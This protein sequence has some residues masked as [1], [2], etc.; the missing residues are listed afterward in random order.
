MSS[1][2]QGNGGTGPTPTE[3]VV[4]DFEGG[5]YVRFDAPKAKLR[6]S[7]P[8]LRGTF[9]PVYS[10]LNYPLAPTDGQLHLKSFPGD[11]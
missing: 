9:D 7:W 8:G 2:L 5:T 4:E 6:R 10:Q 11:S 1:S 3:E